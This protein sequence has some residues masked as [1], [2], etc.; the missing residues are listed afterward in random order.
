M[1]N[2]KAC[3][4][5]FVQ[6][7]FLHFRLIW[8]NSIVNIIENYRIVLLYDVIDKNHNIKFYRSWHTLQSSKLDFRIYWPENFKIDRIYRFYWKNLAKV[9]GP[10]Q[11]W[12]AVGHRT[13]AKV[14]DWHYHCYH[15]SSYWTCCDSTNNIFLNL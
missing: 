13:T 11:F 4:I 9:T 2:K 14:N 15:C 6:D 5:T 3:R 12:L 1:N 8:L 10:N 7:F